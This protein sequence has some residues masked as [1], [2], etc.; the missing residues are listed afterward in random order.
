MKGKAAGV[1]IALISLGIV[2]WQQGRIRN[3]EQELSSI[4]IKFKQ[5]RE[6]A[7]KNTDAADQN[8]KSSQL[9]RN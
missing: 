5:E 9:T 4:E 3:L 8:T 2:I 7:A 1:L 6:S